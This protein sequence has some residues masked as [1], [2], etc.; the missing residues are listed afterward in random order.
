[1]ENAPTLIITWSLLLVLA[2]WVRVE[3]DQWETKVWP[4]QILHTDEQ[5][6]MIKTIHSIFTI[7]D[8]YLHIIMCLFSE[9]KVW[10]IVQ[11]IVHK[12]NKKKNQ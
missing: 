10:K 6:T 8:T 12:G 3:S 2:A 9:F 4:F 11:L 1:M 5:G 7:I